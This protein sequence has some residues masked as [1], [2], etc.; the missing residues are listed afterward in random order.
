MPRSRRRAISASSD[1]RSG[2]AGPILTRGTGRSGR[3]ALGAAS[4]GLAVSG[5][6]PVH[7]GPIHLLRAK[8]ELEALANHARQE[9]THRVLLPAS[10]LHHGGNRRPCGRLQH[11]ND[12]ARLA[13]SVLGTKDTLASLGHDGNPAATSGALRPCSAAAARVE[14][15]HVNRPSVISKLDPKASRSRRV[16]CLRDLDT[17]NRSGGGGGRP[18]ASPERVLRGRIHYSRL[19]ETNSHKN[20]PADRGR[21]IHSHSV[22]SSPRSRNGSERRAPWLSSC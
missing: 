6:N 2:R 21:A 4:A 20:P 18:Q 5:C 8:L 17:Q 1:L 12:A 19:S 3:P 16:A 11:G 15:A 14:T 7:P 13:A 10:C 9:A 22:T